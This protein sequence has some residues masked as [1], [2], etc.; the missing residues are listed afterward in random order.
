MAARAP[1]PAAGDGRPREVRSADDR[2]NGPH[3]ALPTASV[4]MTGANLVRYEAARR[5]LALR[6][7]KFVH[8]P[9]AGVTAHDGMQPH[10]RMVRRRTTIPPRMI[11]SIS[12][13]TKV[14]QAIRDSK[15]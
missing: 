3:V 9:A 10:A 12:Q 13:A 2:E 6:A 14:A 1:K 8:H 7:E 11:G 15:R 5:A 4:Q